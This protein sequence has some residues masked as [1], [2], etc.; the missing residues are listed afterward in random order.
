MRFSRASGREVGITARSLPDKA[1]DLIDQASA[2]VRL[3]AGAPSPD[4]RELEDQELAAAGGDP[5][6]EVTAED[7]AQVVSRLRRTIR[8]ELDRKLS[9]MLLSGELN[10]GG[11]VDV[12]VH[13]G[14]L[15]LAVSPRDPA[16]GPRPGPME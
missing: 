9:R 15:R 14:G 16:P 13:D 1:I 3:R 4:V 12:D 11:K 2:R 10:P 5:V 6:P 8:S 7:I